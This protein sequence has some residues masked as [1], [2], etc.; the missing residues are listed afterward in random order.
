LTGAD[1]LALEKR[2]ASGTRIQR[3]PAL[4]LDLMLSSLES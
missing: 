4:L 1:E 3:D 2:G